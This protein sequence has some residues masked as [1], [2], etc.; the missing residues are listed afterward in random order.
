MQVN[1]DKKNAARE[2][3]SVKW[4][5]LAA[6]SA[7]VTVAFHCGAIRRS[8]GPATF[9]FKLTPKIV[10][11]LHFFWDATP[12]DGD[13]RPLFVPRRKTCELAEFLS[14]KGG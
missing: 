10:S 12:H 11:F 3:G 14:K 2:H 13:G 1:K 6:R 4:R 8:S 7:S 5:P 9:W